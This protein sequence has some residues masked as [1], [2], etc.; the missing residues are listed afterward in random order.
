[1]HPD[2]QIS[3]WCSK[4]ICCDSNVTGSTS[5]YSSLIAIRGIWPHP[6]ALL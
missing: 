3:Q 5:L 2:K 4:N 6:H 1:L